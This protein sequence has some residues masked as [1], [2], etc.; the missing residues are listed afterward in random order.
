M[1]SILHHNTV[2][3]FHFHI[4]KRDDFRVTQSPKAVASGLFLSPDSHFDTCS[5]PPLKYDFFLCPPIMERNKGLIN[6]A[7][8]KHSSISERMREDNQQPRKLTSWKPPYFLPKNLLVSPLGVLCVSVGSLKRISALFFPFRLPVAPLLLFLLKKEV[9]W[10]SQQL[11][12]SFPCMSLAGQSST[13]EGLQ[14][15]PE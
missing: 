12:L 13:E 15:G 8:V 10:L 5:N 2:A 9:S 1:S 11:L 4:I 3:G 14:K 6:V 7:N